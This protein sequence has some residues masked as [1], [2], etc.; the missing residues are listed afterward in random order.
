[1]TYSGLKLSYSRDTAPNQRKTLYSRIKISSRVI[2]HAN[3]RRWSLEGVMF[4][5]AMYDSESLTNAQ[6]DVQSAEME[7]SSSR[8]E[9]THHHN[10]AN[11]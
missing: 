10:F 7:Y 1:M 3:N 4:L 9:M 8:L 6:R 2:E 5:L 11:V